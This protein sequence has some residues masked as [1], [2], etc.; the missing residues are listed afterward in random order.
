MLKNNAFT[1]IKAHLG[2]YLSWLKQFYF[3]RGKLCTL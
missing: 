2:E 3:L 1:A